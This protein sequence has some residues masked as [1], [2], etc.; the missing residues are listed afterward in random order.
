MNIFYNVIYSCNGKAEIS[1]SLL[2]SSVTR[3]PSEIILICSFAAQETFIIIIIIIIINVENRCAPS[4]F[5]GKHHA[6]FFPQDSLMKSKFKWTAF[7]SIWSIMSPYFK[8]KYIY[9]SYWP[10]TFEQ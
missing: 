4:Y 10:Q 5:C 2:H 3:D 6:W 8:T 9:I 7:K 1:A